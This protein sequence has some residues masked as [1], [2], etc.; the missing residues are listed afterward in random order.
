M[1]KDS[2]G[3]LLGWWGSNPD[4]TPQTG[5]IPDTIVDFKLSTNHPNNPNNPKSPE[6]SKGYEWV[7]E[8]QCVEDHTKKQVVFTG[9]N[10]YSRYGYL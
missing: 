10:F 4:I 1:S 2:P 5:W 6:I 8:F 3:E 7:L 9:I